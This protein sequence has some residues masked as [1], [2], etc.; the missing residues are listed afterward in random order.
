MAL[1]S[2]SLTEF[3]NN[4]NSRTS[5]LSG[6]SA[7]EPKLIIEKRKVP[8][9][10]SGSA[11]YTVSVIYA[12]QDAEGNVLTSKV[13]FEATVRYPLKGTAADITA[14][15]AV[16][17]DIIAGDEYGNSVTTQEYLS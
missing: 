16:F 11:E 8:S 3:S 1:M 10:A 13:A 5:T 7:S 2:T 14:A 6:H 12:T 4:G 15:L 9:N 17:R